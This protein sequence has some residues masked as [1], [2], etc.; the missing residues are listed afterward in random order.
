MAIQTLVTLID[1]FDGS[2]ADLTVNFALEGRSYEIDLTNKHADDL[3]KAMK[4]FIDKARR[5]QGMVGNR[6]R[7]SLGPTTSPEER[8][9]IR[10]WASSKGIQISDRGRIASSVVEQFHE[11]QRP[12]RREPRKQTADA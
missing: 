12:A 4:P 1:D 10:E 5:T 6:R 3:R 9:A 7:R 2:K 11:A 8:T